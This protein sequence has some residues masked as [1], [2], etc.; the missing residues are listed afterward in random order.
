MSILNHKKIE[1]YEILSAVLFL[2]MSLIFIAIGFANL[3]YKYILKLGDKSIIITRS[4]FF[5]CKKERVFS[6]GELE[7]A[8]I[9]SKSFYSYG[10]NISYTK[11]YLVLKAGEKIPIFDL[12]G[13][14]YAKNFEDFVD[15]IND[16]IDNN[17]N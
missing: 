16:Y 13:L 6:F 8:E 10:D 17:M 3:T 11:I 1:Y 5:C 7:R 2:M 4:R 9:I 14:N 15:L 12:D